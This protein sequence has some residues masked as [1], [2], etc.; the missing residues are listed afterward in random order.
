MDMADSDNTVQ[1]PAPPETPAKSWIWLKDTAGYPSV[2]VTFVTIAFWVT[3]FWFV[4]S[5]VHKLGP[6]EF[7]A[8]DPAAASAYLG[9]LL[10]L[11]FG[12]KWTDAKLGVAPGSSTPAAK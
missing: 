10:A 4:V 2:T 7:R 11:Y 8:F 12:R 6:V 9:P 1:Q 5:I 3:T